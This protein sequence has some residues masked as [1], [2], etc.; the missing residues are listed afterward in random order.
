MV[1]GLHV[2]VGMRPEYVP[3]VLVPVEVTRGEE[4]LELKFS[5]LLVDFLSPLQVVLLGY[6]VVPEQTPLDQARDQFGEELAGEFEALVSGFEFAGT[7]SLT[8]RFVFTNDA[9]QT[10]ERVA[11]E[12]ECDAVFIPAASGQ[13]DRVLVPL[14]GDT[15]LKMILYFVKSLVKGGD[16]ESVTLLT[17]AEGEESSEDREMMLNGARKH[18][19]DLG[20][21]EDLVEI[22]VEV[23]KDPVAK[24]T[25]VSEGYDFIV[26]GES[27]PSVSNLVFGEVPDR[28]GRRAEVPILVVKGAAD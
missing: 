2:P 24:I 23:S 3:T 1:P 15:N 25:E 19:V 20:V 21:S 17:V 11:N 7:E 6:F 10:L 13:T 4:E 18:L 12:E 8:T 16:V 9:A 5:P 22:R 27:E 14:R 28:V 26:M